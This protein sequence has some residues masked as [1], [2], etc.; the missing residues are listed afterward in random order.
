MPLTAGDSLPDV[1]SSTKC[2][3]SFQRRILLLF[4]NVDPRAVE[5]Y[6]S[7]LCPSLI[8]LIAH[9]TGYARLG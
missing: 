5:S 3:L 8:L 9:N 7:N 1:S 6:P 2:H 4:A